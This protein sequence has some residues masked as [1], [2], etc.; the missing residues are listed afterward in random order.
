MALALHERGLFTWPEWAATLATR[1]SARRRPA[2]PT[3]AR[4]I[5]GTGSTRSS[6][7][8]PRRASTD[9]QTLQ[10]Y[11]EAWDRAADRTPHGQHDQ[12][13]RGDLDAAHRQGA[14]AGARAGEVPAQALAPTAMVAIAATVM[15]VPSPMMKVATTPAQNS[16]CASAN[17]STRM[18]PEHGR[19]PTA[20]IAESPRRQPP[21]PASCSG[22]GACA[23]PRGVA[24]W[25]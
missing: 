16:P 20:T 3:P 22:S 24:S 18:A 17:T 12:Q 11:R 23:W 19:K 2:I 9:R 7:S 10:R 4:P 13:R 25:A 14:V 8:W 5:T 15:A 21:G 1:S 6:A